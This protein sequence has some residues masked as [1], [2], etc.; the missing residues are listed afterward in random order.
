[1]NAD[2]P[3]DEEWVNFTYDEIIEMADNGTV[4]PDDVLKW[5][6]AKQQQQM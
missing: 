5:A 4:V 1:M 3:P 6:Y 2:L